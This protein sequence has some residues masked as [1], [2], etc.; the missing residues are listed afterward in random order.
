MGSE[1]QTSGFE[2]WLCHT[3]ALSALWLLLLTL[4]SFCEDLPSPGTWL[5]MSSSKPLLPP[6]RPQLLLPKTRQ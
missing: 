3:L 4:A 5:V 6:P 2:S 1:S